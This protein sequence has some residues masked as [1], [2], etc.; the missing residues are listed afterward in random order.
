MPPDRKD[1]RQ[2]RTAAI[3]ALIARLYH[4]IKS[5]TCQGE[6][7][8]SALV[9]LIGNLRTTMAPFKVERVVFLLLNQGYIKE[10]KEHNQLVRMHEMAGEECIQQAAAEQQAVAGR[11]VEMPLS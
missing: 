5:T 10:I 6:R 7:N 2:D 1:H 4:E 11:R 8:F 3:L 9:L